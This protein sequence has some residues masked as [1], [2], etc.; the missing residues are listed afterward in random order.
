MWKACKRKSAPDQLLLLLLSLLLL[1]LLLL[2]LFLL[3]TVTV[4]VIGTAENANERA[5]Q[6]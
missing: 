3:L 6:L 1:L 2:F 4:A 5:S